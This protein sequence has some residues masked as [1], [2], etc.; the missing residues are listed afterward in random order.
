VAEG[1]GPAGA[2]APKIISLVGLRGSG[3]STVGELLAQELGVPFLD[4][5][6]ELAERF[7]QDGES[8]GELLGR[9]SEPA[10]R[11]FEERALSACLAADGLRVLATGGGAVLRPANRSALID[12][13]YCVW[14]QADPQ[15]LVRRVHGQNPSVRDESATTRPPLT[16][17]E[18]MQEMEF[19]AE[20][21][22]VHYATVADLR[23]A[24]GGRTP[25]MVA[26]EIFSKLPQ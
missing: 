8:A 7:G 21:R 26:H 18:P 6:H 4:L 19:L 14:L 17:L 12:R 15:E 24:T 2:G 22:A 16:D 25:K 5:D 11:D 9:V 23:C 3:K 13:T 20:K 10:F 1:S